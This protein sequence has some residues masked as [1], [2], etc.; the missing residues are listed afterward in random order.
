MLWLFL[1]F[2][3]FLFSFNKTRAKFKHFYLNVFFL[4]KRAIC[5]KDKHWPFFAARFE[6]C[7]C[8]W[9]MLP[10]IKF[11]KN[12]RYIFK[13]PELFSRQNNS[14]NLKI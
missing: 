11:V 10:M 3:P 13:F 2:F 9:P 6:L 5:L 7:R 4:T 1:L 14:G 12:Y 8:L